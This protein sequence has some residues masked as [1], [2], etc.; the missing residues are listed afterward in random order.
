MDFEAIQSY[1]RTLCKA[2]YIAYKQLKRLKSEYRKLLKTCPANELQEIRRLQNL[3]LSKE[4]SKKYLSANFSKEEL[5]KQ[6]EVLTRKLEKYRKKEEEI[7][8]EYST[9]DMQREKLMEAIIKVVYTIEELQ[10]KDKECYKIVI[11]SEEEVIVLIDFCHKEGH[12]EIAS[13]NTEDI[14]LFP[15]KNKLCV[16]F[17]K[18]YLNNQYNIIKYSLYRD[19]VRLML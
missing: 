10:M 5:A 8:S 13:K 1:F 17:L 9:W 2:Y 6:E 19:Y 3:C 18:A 14:K 4:N 11:K 12:V 15:K 16:D 7:R